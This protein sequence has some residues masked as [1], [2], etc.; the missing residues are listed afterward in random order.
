MALTFQEISEDY[1][2][3]LEQTSGYILSLHVYNL[4]SLLLHF[5]PGAS[6]EFCIFGNKDG[7]NK[8][9]LGQTPL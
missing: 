6:M 8:L 5:N 1:R 4:F 3:K 2:N 7:F 9:L